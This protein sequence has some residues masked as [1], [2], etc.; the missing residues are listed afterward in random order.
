MVVGINTMTMN[1][2]WAAGVAGVLL[3]GLV[4][5][6]FGYRAANPQPMDVAPAGP[7][8]DEA[9]AQGNAETARA[10]E[11]S[12]TG[13]ARGEELL[14]PGGAPTPGLMAPRSTNDVE[15]NINARSNWVD[16]PHGGPR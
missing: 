16:I 2:K 14:L 6:I 8:S 7:G 3:C 4:I 12:Q 13:A 1:T 9:T 10:L 15:A 11:L 5:G